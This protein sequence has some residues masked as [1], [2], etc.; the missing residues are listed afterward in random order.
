MDQPKQK[1]E[2]NGLVCAKNRAG[3]GGGG[4]RTLGTERKRMI[5]RS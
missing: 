5:R 1:R 2:T 3:G 4:R